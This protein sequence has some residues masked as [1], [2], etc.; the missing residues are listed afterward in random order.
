MLN[1]KSFTLLELIV[2]V[3]IMAILVSILLPSLLNARVEAKV[4]VCASNQKQIGEGMYGYSSDNSGKLTYTAWDLGENWPAAAPSDPSSHPNN[5][6]KL[7][8]HGV[9]WTDNINPYMGGDLNT[10]ES[11][12][13]FLE[14]ND[15]RS[16]PA[17]ACPAD[18]WGPSQSGSAAMSYGANELALGK[19]NPNAAPID[20][21]GDGIIDNKKPY[22]YDDEGTSLNQIGQ[23]HA[24]MIIDAANTFAV[25]DAPINHLN[26]SRQGSTHGRHSIKKLYNDIAPDPKAQLMIQFWPSQDEWERDNMAALL[27]HK[28]RFNYLFIDGSVRTLR[29]QSTIGKG[30]LQA[31][32]GIWTISNED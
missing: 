30:S 29:S 20:D 15:P 4:A 18:E 10:W 6:G 1:K 21:N 27:L 14:L 3:A 28:D 2:V 11:K 31:P 25:S 26:S 16:I 19:T 12:L 8:G 24:G 9:S 5:A 22:H 23:M 17:L 7:G 13:G 32:K